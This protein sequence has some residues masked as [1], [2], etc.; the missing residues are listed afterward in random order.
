MNDA[1]QSTETR[2]DSMEVKIRKLDAELM[3]YKES[4]KKLRDGP[5][6]VSEVMKDDLFYLFLSLVLYSFLG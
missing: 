2:I 3:R 1:I 6:K 4:M 5:G